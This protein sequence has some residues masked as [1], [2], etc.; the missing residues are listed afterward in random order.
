[1]KDVRKIARI[2]CW[3]VFAVGCA[4][5]LAGFLSGLTAVS[6]V[7]LLGSIWYLFSGLSFAILSKIVIDALRAR[8]R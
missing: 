4:L 3:I 6:E 2:A 1:M 5:V 7:E 8:E